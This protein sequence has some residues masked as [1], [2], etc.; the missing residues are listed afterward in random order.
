M[1]K[2]SGFEGLRSIAERLG[3]YEVL[4]KP[5]PDQSSLNSLMTSANLSRYQ[6]D[7]QELGYRQVDLEESAK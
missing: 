2:N 4:G 5:L 3:V 1:G 7:G 6:R